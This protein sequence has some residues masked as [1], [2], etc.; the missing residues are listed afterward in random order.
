MSSQLDVSRALSTPIKELGESERWLFTQHLLDLGADDR[1]LRFGNPLSNEAI[2]AY[3]DRIDFG[4]D[5]IFGIFDDGLKLVAAGHFAPTREEAPGP[6]RSAEFGLSVAS[7]ARGAGMGTALFYRAASHARNLQIGT[8]FMHC[9]SQNRAMIRIARKA[10]MD[11]H[12]AQGE[13]DAYLSLPPGDLASAI[14]EGVQQQIAIFDY[15]IKR[16]LLAARSPFDRH[17]ALA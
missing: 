13:A 11:I 12:Q 4:A 2:E 1:Y 10:G 17:V 3:V 16:H 6:I 9:L 5:T 8:L 7:A 15:A 14:E